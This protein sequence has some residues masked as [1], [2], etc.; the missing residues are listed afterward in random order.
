MIAV[1]RGPN[2]V[3][4]LANPPYLKVV[5]KT[6]AILGK[7]LLEVFPE[8]K[9]QK[10]LGILRSVQKTGKPYYGNEVH[11]RL[12][13]RNDGV[14][15]DTYF[16]FVYQ[17]Y[18]GVNGQIDGVLTHA[19]DVTEQVMM[20]KKAEDSEERYRTLFNSID[21][22]FCVLEVLFDNK[23]KAFD[24]RFLETNRVFEEQTGLS[25]AV[26]KTAKELVPDLEGHWF[27]TYGKVARSG[28]PTRFIDGSEAMGRWFD[29]H[30][31]RVGNPSANKVALLFTDITKRRLADEQL[32]KS[33][34]RFRTMADNVPVMVW[35]TTDDDRC[36]YLNKQWY[37]YTG[38][39]VETGLGFGWLDAVHPDDAEATGLVYKHASQQ[40]IPLSS[41]Y[42][43][44]SKDG[45]YRW[46]LDAGLPKFDEQGN[47]EGYI[48][49]VTDIEDVK[50]T[51]SRQK[52]L[53]AITV[54][55][56]EQQEEL[57]TLSAAKD[58]FI[59]LASH[60]LRTPA[61]AVKQYL[62]MVLEGY[63]GDVTDNQKQMLD[64][65]HVNN[66]RQ[67]TIVNDLL[68]VAQVDAGKVK[69]VKQRIDIVKLMR[70]V[71]D[72]QRAKFQS[73]DQVVT[74]DRSRI[75]GRTVRAYVAAD[76][77]RM[78]MVLENIVDNASK[79]TP[80]GKAVTVRVLDKPADSAVKIEVEDT[81]VGIA[82]ADLDKLFHKFTRVDNPLTA[83]V[84]GT[85]LGLYWAKKIVDLHDGAISVRSRPGQGTTFTI[86]LPKK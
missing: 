23:G 40:R 53:E 1:C 22:G 16:N 11:A 52:Q 57:L 46:F 51:L 48:G 41:E 39:T 64:L 54:T 71:L 56:R 55:L 66:E 27:E 14:L 34:K 85:G 6:K 80:I 21:E 13:T 10:I 60:Q 84:D 36:I 58:E 19:T 61:T 37:D 77:N 35:I 62:S 63:A 26:G 18:K 82:K 32:Q 81:G 28:K 67:I 83:E 43:L 86:S 4:E 75:S 33:E 76:A 24:Y 68:K 5:G 74:F 20:R 31:S 2:L 38:Q 12:D 8:L 7:P 49:S 45:S 25:G 15:H 17:P 79:Y 73:R 9:G 70:E 42:R 72:D 3:Y 59:S 30:A 44:R 47:F 29:V 65:A 69:L 78:R 50:Q